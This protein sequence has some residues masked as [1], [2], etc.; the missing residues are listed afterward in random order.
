MWA[1]S[2]INLNE[3]HRENGGSY[4]MIDYQAALAIAKE[5]VDK[6]G[7]EINS[8]MEDDHE[9]VELALLEDYT[10]E[11]AYGWI[12][13]YQSARYVETHKILDGILG[14][15]PFIVEKEAGAVRYPT[16]RPNIDFP[17]EEDEDPSEAIFAYEDRLW[18]EKSM[19]GKEKT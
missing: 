2:G 3:T 16:G 11:K 18:Q 13:Y 7:A 9:Y 10:E 15:P 17:M 19:R 6:I 5:H 12:F 4:S 1:E 8:E 14:T